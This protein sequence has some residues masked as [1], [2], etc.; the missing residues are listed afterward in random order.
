MLA[1]ETYYLL[2]KVD[3]KVRSTQHYFN[4]NLSIHPSHPPQTSKKL[5]TVILL[6]YILIGHVFY[7]YLRQRSTL[8]AIIAKLIS[9][10]N[11]TTV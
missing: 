5:R 6:L 4:P 2:M 10:F 11:K 3:N 1:I 7:L 9:Q 8:I